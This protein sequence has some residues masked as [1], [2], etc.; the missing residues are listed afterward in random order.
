MKKVII[1]APLSSRSG[2][3]EMSR[4]A[5]DV[6][7]QHKHEFDLYV[8]VINWGQ[9]G[10]LFEE[11]ENFKLI[12]ELRIK[13]ESY[14]RSTNGNP[15][16][17]ISL[18]I[19]I[20]NEWKKM[21]KVNVGYTAGIETTHISP[22][23][24]EPSQQM[25]RI[26]VISEHAK[27]AFKNTVFQ[28]ESGQQFGVTTP[29]SVV[30]FPFKQVEDAKINLDLPYD[31][32]FLTVNQWGP[33]KN[34]EGLVSAFIDEF[35]NEEVGLVV[36]TNRSADSVMDKLFVEAAFAELVDS[37][38]P[39]KCKVHLVHGFLDEKEV[40]GF[41]KHPK[42]KAF[43]TSTHGEGFGLPIFEA[44]NEEL[45]VIATN[46]SGH[47]DFLFGLDKNGEEKHLFGKIDHELKQIQ[48]TAVWPGVMEKETMWA[49]PVV[50]SIKSRMREVYK[51]YSRFKNWAKKISDLNSKK[52]SKEKVEDKFL[53]AFSGVAVTK[54]DVA[55]LPKISILTSVFNGDEFIRHFL[56]DITN[57]TIFKEKCELIIVNGNSPGNEEP[58]IKEFIERFPNNIIYK[59][60]ESDPGVYGCWN[61]AAKMA[62]GD[63]LTNAN[64]DDRKAPNFMKELATHLHIEKD[65]DVVYSNNLVTNK[66][67][68][69]WDKNTSNAIYPSE[70][71]S[72]ESMLRGNPPHCMPMW[73]KSL[74]ERFGYFEEKYRSA[75][76][77]EF[78]LRCAF[79]G[80]KFSKLNK[81]L[82][83][84]YFNPRGVS[85]N[86]ENNS[87]KR[88]E[89]KE[90]FKK[91]LS[92]HK[93]RQKNE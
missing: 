60:L 15:D 7:K 84:Y 2:Y 31:F 32:N 36:K 93:E 65:V 29:I 82:G 49:F 89:E 37:K 61:I 67:N 77:W 71:F 72:I 92:I 13:T 41:Y 10:Y 16:F 42:I 86:P 30:H 8:N 69:S 26:I 34:I 38:G 74:H 47:L 9:T 58:I 43:V 59:K 48:P 14:L 90:V 33:R 51:D 17:D 85:T 21:A 46:W 1:N 28:N 44:V 55:S 79:G 91:Y 39:K 64:I 57:Q 52:F 81:P 27:A 45:P 25:D 63:F 70:E 18:Q 62:T 19:T 76:D 35:R 12:Q 80:S 22:A 50:S 4:F 73:R 78:W 20:P 75:S 11:D 24:F 54:V 23:W 56:E 6:L 5:L 88:Q 68:E 66:P 83:L 53:E 87:W 40:H 3:G